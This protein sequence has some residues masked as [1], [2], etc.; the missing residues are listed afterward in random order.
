MRRLVVLLTLLTGCN[1][2]VD[3]S[4]ATMWISDGF[5]TRSGVAVTKELVLTQLKAFKNVEN[6][7][8][9][10]PGDKAADGGFVIKNDTYDVALLRTKEPTLKFSKLGSASELTD[11][12][13]LTLYYV[14]DQG[15]QQKSEGSFSGWRY[16]KGVAYFESKMEAP[17]I[18]IGAGVSDSHG[19]L[20]GILSFKLGAK[21]NYFLPVDYVVTGSDAVAQKVFGAKDDAP[22]FATHRA[23]AKKHTEGLERP[24]DF[25]TVTYTQSFSKTA[26][27]GTLLLLN[28]K[29]APA[30]NGALK[31]KV[32]AV[33]AA[34]AHHTI[35]EGV[36]DAQN[37]QW[38]TL[39]DEQKKL[40]DTL[41]K[42]FGVTYVEQNLAPYEYGELRYRIPFKPFCSKVTDQEVHVLVMTL[43]DGR[44]SGEIGFSDMVNVCSGSEEGEGDALE[45]A[46][47][48]SAATEKKEKD[49]DT[50]KKHKS[51]KKK[52]KR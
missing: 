29:E 26:L 47:G 52:K 19:Q 46:W 2:G 38:K 36:V 9:G 28:K 43:A 12:A 15:K 41:G 5:T 4:L 18:A 44:K 42:T 20:L 48:M 3:L 17:D 37:K 30:Q 16:S 32:E 7:Q 49:H 34:R 45:K 33:D 23:E 6:A 31:Y 51:G 50:K 21:L 1:S 13:V 10:R 27:V 35:A 25:D 11:N 8:T 24:M 40:G 14:D 22:G 39:P